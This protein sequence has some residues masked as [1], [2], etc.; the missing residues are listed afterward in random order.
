MTIL[1]SVC[2]LWVVLWGGVCLVYMVVVSGLAGGRS[3]PGRTGF[4][5]RLGT[6]VRSML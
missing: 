1:T 2:L 5:V 6:G 4:R 3:L